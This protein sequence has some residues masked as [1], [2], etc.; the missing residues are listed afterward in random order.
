MGTLVIGFVALVIVV[1]IAAFGTAILLFPRV[2]PETDWAQD[3]DYRRMD[4]RY[5]ESGE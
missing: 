4:R 5:R 3:I 2:I 1:V